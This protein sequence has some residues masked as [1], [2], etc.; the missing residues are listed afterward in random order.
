MLQ[1]YGGGSLD[2]KDPSIDILVD[3]EHLLRSPNLGGGFELIKN[4]RPVADTARLYMLFFLSVWLSCN[5]FV[6]I[7]FLII[8][9]L[10]V[11]NFLDFMFHAGSSL[12][13]IIFLN[14]YEFQLTFVGFRLLPDSME[15]NILCLMSLSRDDGGVQFVLPFARSL[16]KSA[17]LFFI[18]AYRLS[19]S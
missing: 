4:F 9:L 17:I 3:T 8:K 5:L 18:I 2:R 16:F 11:F 10:H 19:N 1:F 15:S 7:R 6:L 12:L 14:V 13:H